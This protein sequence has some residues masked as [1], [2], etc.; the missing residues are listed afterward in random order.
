MSGDESS[1][2]LQPDPPSGSRLA[3]SR[4][5]TYRHPLFPGWNYEMLPDP[6]DGVSDILLM[7]ELSSSDN[8]VRQHPVVRVN[9]PP[10]GRSRRPSKTQQLFQRRG[11]SMSAWSDISRSSFRLEER[12]VMCAVRATTVT[13]LPMMFQTFRQPQT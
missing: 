13:T 2:H 9:L 5:K 12:S 8:T 4:G 11:R 10:G 6:G 3:T 1:G 7:D